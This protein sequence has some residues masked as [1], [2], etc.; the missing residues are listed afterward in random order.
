MRKK[1]SIAI[2][3]IPGSFHHQ[4]ALNIFGD[5]VEIV[6]FPSFEEVAKS[7]KD[8]LVDYAV[9]A[10]ENSIAGA[11]LPN[12]DLIDRLG[13]SIESEYYLAISHNLMALPG[14]KIE[15]IKEVGSHPMALLQ[16]QKYFEQ[17][18]QIKLVPEKD[19]ASVAKKIK[20]GKISGVGAIA[21]EKAAEIYGL[22]ILANNI[23]SFKDNYTR[24]IILKS[25]E[26]TALPNATKSSL[27][28]T[29]KNEKG[30]LAK[31]L[32]LL[33]DQGL[34]LSKIQSIPVMDRPWDYAF[35]VDIIIQDYSNY[36][37]AIEGLRNLGATVKILGEYQNQKP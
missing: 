7:V 36:L 24:F 22:D 15:D 14:L 31:T 9:M 3:G 8:N 33:S 17:Y 21:S 29:I 34:D 2:Q 26:A 5:G 19:T 30:G 32:S 27:K 4:V 16:C 13:L 20:E 23:Q 10:I 25:T 37:S 6:G 35:F 12:F 11:I 1:I 28:F 18:P